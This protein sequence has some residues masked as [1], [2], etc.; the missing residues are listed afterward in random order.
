MRTA[1]RKHAWDFAFVIGLVLAALLVGGYIL[2]NQRFYLPHWVPVLGS[3]FVDYKAQFSTAQ[4]VTPGQGQTIQVA[5]VDVGDITKVDLV[6][7]RAVVTMKIRR[8][9]TPIYKDATALLRPKT[10][11]NDMVIELDPGSK[12]AGTAPAGWAVPVNQTLPNVNFDEILSSL[13]T[14][15]RSYLQLLVGAAGEGLGGQG[16]ALSADLKRFE[17][18]GR[19]LAKLNGALAVRERNIRRSIHNFRLLSQALGDKDDDLAALVDSSSRVFTAFANQDANLRSALQELPGAL[20]TTST[21]L[22]KVDKLG[23]AL[24][25]TLGA[26]R[27]GAR[28]LGPSLVQTRPF[29]QQTTPIIQNQLRPFARAALPVAKV[30]RPAA[31]DLAVVTPKLTT[32]VQVLNYLLNELAY[33]PPGREEGYLFWASWAS[34]AGATVFSTQDAHG[35]IRHGLVLAS[36][37]TLQVLHQLSGPVPQLGTLGALLNPPDQNVVCPTTSQ[38]GAAPT[39]SGSPTPAVPAVPALPVRGLGRSR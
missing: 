17:P 5:G 38:A 32:S 35:P 12:T 34:H 1:I 23:K 10:G 3:D 11:L 7:G 9:F 14:D 8:K 13:D 30:L 36:C 29:L 33:N 22:S 31:R 26:L 25:P 16:K 18:T 4:S 15:T 19:Y 39:Q 27:P 37:S 6:D 21:T 28:A 20:D 2:S 24:G